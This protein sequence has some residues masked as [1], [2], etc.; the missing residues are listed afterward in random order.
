[1]GLM[2]FLKGEYIEIVE[3]TDDTRHTLTHRFA[4]ADKAIK[5]GAQLIV[6]ESQ[7]AQ[8]LYLGQPTLLSLLLRWVGSVRALQQLPL[9]TDCEQKMPRWSFSRADFEGVWVCCLIGHAPHMARP[10]MGGK[11]RSA[12][13]NFKN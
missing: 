11:N 5:N 9:V 7:I 13:Q 10:G 4:D 12:T 6:R 1:M 8:F 2:D 3:W